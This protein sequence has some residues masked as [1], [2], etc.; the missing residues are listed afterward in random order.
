[1]SSP[2]SLVAAYGDAGVRHG[3]SSRK[4][5]IVERSPSFDPYTELYDANT[6]RRHAPWRI[7]SRTTVVP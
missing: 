2:A 7:A 5:E 6:S 4:A 3:S 1:M